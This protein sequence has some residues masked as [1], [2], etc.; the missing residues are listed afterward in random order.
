MVVFTGVN[1]NPPLKELGVV[2]A[3]FY[4]II[5]THDLAYVK[6]GGQV[7]DT[8]PTREVPK[9]LENSLLTSLV[10]GK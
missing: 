2:V 1:S 8:T 9:A 7:L 5:A 4:G 3:P 10:G 6:A